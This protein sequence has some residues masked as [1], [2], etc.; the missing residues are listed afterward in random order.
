MEEKIEMPNTNIQ[1][2]PRVEIKVKNYRLYRL[3]FFILGFV[4]VLLAMRFTFKLLGANPQNF[5]AMIVYGLS[6]ALLLPFRGLFPR[7]PVV[8]AETVPRVLEPSTLIAMIIYAL[9]AW[10]IAKWILIFKTKPSAQA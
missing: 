3:V 8:I 7:S 1:A 6:E 10:G 4:E 9:I 2:G 5:F